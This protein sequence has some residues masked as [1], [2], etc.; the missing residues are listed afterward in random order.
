MPII[1]QDR[2]QPSLSSRAF[3]TVN[4]DDINDNAPQFQQNSYDFWIKENSPSGT[5]VGTIL[6]VDPDLGENA[7]IKFKIFGGSDAKFF[8]IEENE[9]EPGVVRIRS[10]EEFD[11]ESSTNKFFVELQAIR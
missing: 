8:E 10:R 6:T 5:I 1:A 9:N 3:L 2:G 4:L 7:Q 11:Y